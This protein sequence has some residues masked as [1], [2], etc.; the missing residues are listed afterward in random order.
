[1]LLSSANET[2]EL[3]RCFWLPATVSIRGIWIDVGAPSLRF[4]KGSMFS[5]SAMLGSRWF[6]RRE[7]GGE[8]MLP[9]L[10]GEMIGDFA[11]L[12]LNQ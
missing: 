3:V 8:V 4:D 9:P 5:S 6:D 2:T 11:G 1:M 7:V 12:Y 10:F